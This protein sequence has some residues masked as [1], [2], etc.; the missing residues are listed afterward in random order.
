[1]NYKIL[2]YTL[3][4]VSSVGICA[5][6]PQQ[7]PLKKYQTY[8]GEEITPQSIARLQPQPSKEL[9]AAMVGWMA[10]NKELLGRTIPES[11]VGDVEDIRAGHKQFNEDIQAAGY[12]NHS[13]YNAALVVELD[14][15]PHVIKHA[16]IITR[17][18]H[19]LVSNPDKEGNYY[20]RDSK[21]FS[22]DL[23]PV[24]T[25]QTV[26]QS[27]H[28]LRALETR[29]GH[30][31]KSR[32]KI[33]KTYLFT[34]PGREKE[35]GSFDSNSIV[36]QEYV[37]GMVPLRENLNKVA[38]LSQ[39]TIGAAFIMIKGGTLWNA[40]GNMLVDEENPEVLGYFDYEGPDNEGAHRFFQ[41]DDQK[42]QGNISVG[43]S[44]FADIL[45]AA[46]KKGHA[47]E[48]QISWFAEQIQK[49]DE[50][51]KER[52][53]GIVERLKSELK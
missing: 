21:Y 48:K 31:L 29:E 15:K 6:V 33:P 53:N 16:G 18:F 11:V 47:V 13:A 30:G 24:E 45:I 43:L 42:R 9:A 2:S 50:L 25:F 23:N 5:M 41:K 3:A 46:K 27:A 7:T 49:D 52:T 1:M 26:S 44:E 19:T 40:G 37:S 12:K 20:P 51:E 14:G 17:G 8:K 35:T 36:V 28:Y 34:I 32:F 4:L 38:E 39:E 10:K 22:K